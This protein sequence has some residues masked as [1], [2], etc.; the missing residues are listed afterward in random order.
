M[1]NKLISSIT[2]YIKSSWNREKK[3]FK[4][5]GMFNFQTKEFVW[6]TVS[7]PPPST[8]FSSP[9]CSLHCASNESQDMAVDCQ[10]WVASVV[11]PQVMEQWFGSDSVSSMWNVTKS[12]GR[13]PHL[14]SLSL[15]LFPSL[16][17]VC[18]VQ[19]ATITIPAQVWR[20]AL[21]MT[22]VTLRPVSSVVNGLL[23]SP[24]VLCPLLT[25]I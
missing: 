11:G 8:S 14:L 15:S 10:T 13:P 23:V 1:V 20:M 19:V 4:N 21:G 6:F 16:D 24:F 7:P 12:L 17:R 25:M 18:D 9:F 5:G 2:G 3:F 22:A